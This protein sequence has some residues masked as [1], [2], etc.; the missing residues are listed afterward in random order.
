MTKRKL[1][2]CQFFVIVADTCDQTIPGSLAG[3]KKR[4]PGNRLQKGVAKT[5]PFLSLNS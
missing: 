2:V 4:D 5:N 1:A 3:K